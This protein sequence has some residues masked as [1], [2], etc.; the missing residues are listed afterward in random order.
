M[1]PT[2]IVSV[3]RRDG[4]SYELR[5]SKTDRDRYFIITDELWEPMPKKDAVSKWGEI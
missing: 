5:R 2:F 3:K 4:I 1:P